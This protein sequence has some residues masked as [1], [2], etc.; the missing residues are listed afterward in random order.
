MTID[1]I[2]KAA[3]AFQDAVSDSYWEEHGISDDE[4]CVGMLAALEALGFA[5]KWSAETIR[6]AWKAQEDA[7]AQERRDREAV[8]RAAMTP[9]QRETED[10]IA[11]QMEETSKMLLARIADDIFSASPMFALLRGKSP[12]TAAY[13]G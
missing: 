9:E 10:L 7:E 3:R 8:R 11:R 4:A 12:N 1:D 5:D 6:S 13:D 2:A